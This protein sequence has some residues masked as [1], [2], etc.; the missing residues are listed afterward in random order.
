MGESQPLTLIEC[1]LSGTPY[2]ASALGDIPAML[3]SEL[4]I[5]GSIIPIRDNYCDP[6]EIALSI[7]SFI[8]NS[9]L[10]GGYRRRA[11]LAA[12]KFSWDNMISDYGRVYQEV[13][14]EEVY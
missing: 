11:Q 2:I 7:I 6:E 13:L 10:D 14:A 3:D 9:S 5:A 1:L 12:Q 8:N 4:G